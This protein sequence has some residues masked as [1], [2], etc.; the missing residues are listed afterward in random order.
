[1]PT[2][3]APYFRV[4]QLEAKTLSWWR[5]RQ[6]KIDMDPPY[7]RRGGLWSPADKAYLIDSILNGF[8]IPKLYIADFNW[9]D[10][11]L[12]RKRLPYAIIDGKQRL[13]A[14][15]DFYEGR[16]ALNAD[17]VCRDNPRLALAGLSYPDLL[18]D[19]ADIAEVFDN[20]NLSVMSVSASSDAP[21]RELFIRLNRSKPLTG[22]EIRNAMSG[23]AP[24][25]I[26]KLAQ[27]DFFRECVSFGMQR[28]QDHNAAAKLLMFEH[29]E[30]PTGTK[31]RSVD[32]FV[33]D[34]STSKGGNRKLE[35]AGR[36]VL[37][38]LEVM[39][40]IFLP[41]DPLLNSTGVL[42]V[43][44]W[45]IR[46]Q[47]E[48]LHHRVWEFLRDFEESRRSNRQNV[49]THRTSAVDPQLV[50]FDMYNRSTN[51]LQSHE[52]RIRILEERF[53]SAAL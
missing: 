38:V 28:G 41:K 23:P 15:F 46:G 27:H 8:D 29:Y 14:V 40:A 42:P 33:R 2:R 20:Y 4:V 19:H 48:R 31:K 53:R 7:Q 26:R 17:F 5:T 9:G 47:P 10:S 12:N 30:K 22:A 3:N 43:Y 44:Y 39:A 18:R 13:E 6:A 34:V 16:I 51:D 50:Q 49:G 24:K 35:L 37:D 32:E 52:G 45:F 11:P 1:M 25:V 21:I 36:H